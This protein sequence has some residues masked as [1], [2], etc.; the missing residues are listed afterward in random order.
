M[1]EVLPSS[2]GVRNFFAISQI[3]QIIFDI[4]NKMETIYNALQFDF[5]PINSRILNA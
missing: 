3:N 1:L 4:L 2:R 5:E